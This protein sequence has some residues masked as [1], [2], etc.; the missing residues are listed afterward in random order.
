MARDRLELGPIGQI[1]LLAR[2]AKRAEDFYRDVLGLPHLYTFGD[3]VFFDANGTRLFIRAVPEE[4]WRPSSIVYFRVPDID[5][6]WAAVE[7]SGAPTTS[8][9]Q[10]VHRHDDGTEEWMAFFEDTEGNT[11]ALITAF[12]PAST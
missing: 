11:L 5:A 6:A 10:R 7:E 1:S 3:L 9:P 2:D 4:E 8:G 12:A